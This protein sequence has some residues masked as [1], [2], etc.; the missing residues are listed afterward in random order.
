[1]VYLNKKDAEKIIKEL[2]N[3][4]NKEIKNIIKKIKS[5]KKRRVYITNNS[6]IRRLLQKAFNEKR[7]VKMKKSF[8]IL[9][10][11]VS[12]DFSMLRN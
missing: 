8:H 10:Y 3:S 5:S 6:E 9:K 12:N 4:P 7:K 11:V 1:M 2:S